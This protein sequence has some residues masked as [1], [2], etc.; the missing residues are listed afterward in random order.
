M[1]RLDTIVV[2]VAVVV[3]AAA[4][5]DTGTWLNAYRHVEIK[6][7]PDAVW[8]AMGDFD[9]FGK[10][11]PRV[12]EKLAEHEKGNAPG[13]KRRITLDDRTM[14]WQEL[15]LHDAQSRSY[16][17]RQVGDS[18]IQVKDYEAVISVIESRP[19]VSTVIWRG[20]FKAKE[21][22]SPQTSDSAAIGAVEAF[23]DA[24]LANLKRMLEQRG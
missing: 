10:W 21:P 24:G 23:Y 22:S 17:Y 16:R 3:P 14:T 13:T 6:A 9:A 20:K 4:F 2:A 11:H 7:S 19:G 5:A 18:P 15:T 1:K 12:V 8:E